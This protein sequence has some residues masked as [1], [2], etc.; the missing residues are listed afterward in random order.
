MAKSKISPIVVVFIIFPL[1][2]FGFY[3]MQQQHI[4]SAPTTEEA[5]ATYNRKQRQEFDAFTKGIDL[6][7]ASAIPSS[8]HGYWGKRLSPGNKKMHEERLRDWEID[9]GENTI[10][11]HSENPWIQSRGLGPTDYTSL[12][13]VEND[14]NSW[15]IVSGTTV[16]GDHSYDS[17]GTMKLQDGILS[18]EM[19]RFDDANSPHSIDI[20]NYEVDIS[21][22]RKT[23]IKRK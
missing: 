23:K 18:I 10:S 4:H 3:T 11:M 16:W 14:E 2:V 22:S 20:S 6:S 8:L 1:V 13:L 5:T 15:T 12:S 7:K 21:K 19:Q 17:H 9:I